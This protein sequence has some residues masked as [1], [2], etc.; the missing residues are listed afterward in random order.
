MADLQ[1]HNVVNARATC[2][3]GTSG[4]GIALPVVTGAGGKKI[5]RSVMGPRRAAVLIAVHVLMVAH[6]VHY[7]AV[8]RSLSPVEPSESMSTLELGQIN[9]GFVFFAL[10]LLGTAVFGR[11]FCGWGCHLVAYQDFCS[12]LMK[13]IKVHPKPFRSRLLVFVPLG[14]ALY[15][16]VYP[17][18]KRMMLAPPSQEF[19]GLSSHLMTEDYWKT[20]PGPVFAVL[21]VVVCGFGA[22]YFLG[23]KGFCTYGCPYGGFFGLLDKA[24]LGRILVSDACAQCGHCTAVCTSNVR[25]HQEVK[26]YG[27]V[28]DPGC[29]KCMDCVSVCPNGALRFGLGP[30]SVVR[31]A[32]AG[33]RAPKRYDFT[34]AEE[35]VLVLVFLLATTSFR[36]LYDGPPLL[37]SVGL[38][39]ITAYLALKLWR[40]RIDPTVRVQNLRIKTAGVLGLGGWAFAALT[41]AWLAFAGHSGFVQW[42]RTWGRHHMNLTEASQADVFGGVAVRPGRYSSKHH[43]A[44]AESERH[45]R[46]ADR[47]GL[48]DTI[49]VKLGL[50]WFELLHGND[51]QAERYIRRAAEVAPSNPSCREHVVRILLK[52]GKLAEAIEEMEALLRLRDGTAADHF[53]LAAMLADVGRMGEAVDHLRT[54][55]SLNPQ[56]ARAQFLLGRQLRQFGRYSE[57]VEPLQRAS[58][59]VLTDTDILIELGMAQAGAGE[60]GEAIET[61]QRVLVLA[62]EHAIASMHLS[63]LVQKSRH[64]TSEAA[65]VVGQER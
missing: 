26:L 58:A 29:M 62:P 49:E 30:P 3:A 46:L 45:F 51:Q 36:G 33:V 24:S 14:L 65:D 20:F 43:T 27:M 60:I 7:L 52:R 55:V 35:L 63:A 21:T 38:G 48:V 19:P 56:A 39:A 41:S 11:F 32:T 61:F 34:L 31:R 5:K 9:A 50:A 8:G 40:V 28:V 6:V 25:V 12:W 13:K 4:N 2:S 17:S 44:A 53:Q 59:L 18:V 64:T 54:C 57:A 22:V 37:M 15:M 10:A 42:H 16:F 23:A 47:W 1:G